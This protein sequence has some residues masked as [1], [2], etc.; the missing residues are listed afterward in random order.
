MKILAQIISSTDLV[1][2]GILVLWKKKRGQYY[3]QTKNF[4]SLTIWHKKEIKVR[5]KKNKTKT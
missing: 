3:R 2:I 1:Q 5:K 4:A